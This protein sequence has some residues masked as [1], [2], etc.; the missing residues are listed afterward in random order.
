MSN[1][2]LI[3]II[4]VFLFVA[5]TTCFTIPVNEIR[6]AQSVFVRY[7]ITCDLKLRVVVSAFAGNRYTL[8]QILELDD[9]Y[10]Y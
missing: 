2:R 4:V 10:L 5:L 9:Q 3:E 1:Q 6:D 8:Q 7:P